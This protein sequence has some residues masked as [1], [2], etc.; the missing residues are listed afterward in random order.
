MVQVAKKKKKSPALYTGL[1]STNQHQ[2]INY[3]IEMLGGHLLPLVKFQRN[4][5]GC[6]VAFLM[7]SISI[8]KISENDGKH[9]PLDV[10]PMCV[11]S[12]FHTA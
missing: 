1:L 8:F 10:V 9:D 12:A 4:M 6:R 5:L 3:L 2:P 7:L 11:Y